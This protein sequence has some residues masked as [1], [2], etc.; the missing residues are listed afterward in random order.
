MSGKSKRQP[1]TNTAELWNRALLIF[2]WG[3]VS[4]CRPD[5][6]TIQRVKAEFWNVA[7]SMR[8]GLVTPRMIVEQLRDEYGL[9]TDWERR[10]RG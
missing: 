6:E 2:L 7:D 5:P 10:D 8:R 3:W 1:R 4:V 9:V